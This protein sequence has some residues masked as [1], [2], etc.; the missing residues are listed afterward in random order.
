[1]S[2]NT[3][4]PHRISE[5]FDAIDQN[6]AQRFVE[7]LTDD[8]VFR[9][10]SAP[11]VKGR[12]AIAMAVGA[13]FSSISG[14]QHELHAVWSGTDSVAC[15]GDVTY[16]RNDGSEITL[17]FAD[18]FELRGNLISGYRIYIDIAPLFAPQY[19]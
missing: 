15:E 13:F 2:A 10:G 19:G 16:R 1:M 9:F 12:K 4:V 3:A 5:L 6:D 17:P 11:A 8:A 7:F 18:V 14:C